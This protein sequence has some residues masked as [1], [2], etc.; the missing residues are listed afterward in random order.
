MA[1]E[2]FYKN[3]S[4]HMKKGRK[5][6]ATKTIMSELGQIIAKDRHAFIKV[7]NNAGVFVSKE[8]SDAELIDA[9][10]KNIANNK[11][12]INGTSFLVSHYNK[13]YGFDGKLKH[14]EAGFCAMSKN[15]TSSF[16]ESI[17]LG[18]YE[19]F[20]DLKH[21]NSS[22][23]RY[24]DE[25]GHDTH[26]NLA[27]DPVSAVAQGVG[28][29]AQLG[30]SIAQNKYAKKYGGQELAK[31]KQAAQ[32][33]LIQSVLQQKQ[34]QT[35]AQNKLAMQS[36]KRKKVALIIGGSLAGLLIIGGI[37]YYVKTKK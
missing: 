6:E 29:L 26:Y 20:D 33:A 1:A 2:V 3:L 34:A 18:K 25:T 31:N 35:D 10:F 13:V 4:T 22:Y 19:G 16:C 36:A 11:K 30:S 28:S 21:A 37:I 9:F 8:N 14:N 27:G 24:K 5:I 32:S 15:M 12:L 17:D 7:L 23:S